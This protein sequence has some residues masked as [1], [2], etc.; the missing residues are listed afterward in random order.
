MSPLQM[1]SLEDNPEMLDQFP[2]KDSS[3]PNA[4]DLDFPAASED[5]EQ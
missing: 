3:T 2:P 1:K 4:G 5:V